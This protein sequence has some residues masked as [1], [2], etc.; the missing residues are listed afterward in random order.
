MIIIEKEKIE[1][2]LYV[3]ELKK[4]QITKHNNEKSYKKFKEKIEMLSKE[5]EEIYK[6]NEDIINKVLTEYL[7]DVK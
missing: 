6:Q 3:I 1:L 5:K 7:K 2:A 4:A